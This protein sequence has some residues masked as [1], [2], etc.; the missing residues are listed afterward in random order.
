MIPGESIS[1]TAIAAKMRQVVAWPAAR[2]AA[3]LSNKQDVV[4]PV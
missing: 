1:P 2:S 4:H 3:A